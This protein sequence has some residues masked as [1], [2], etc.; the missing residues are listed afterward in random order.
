[1]KEFNALCDRFRDPKTRIEAERKLLEFRKSRNVLEQSINVVVSKNATG[2]AK[3]QATSVCRDVALESWMRIGTQ[4]QNTIREH[5]ITYVVTNYN[6]LEKFVS[7]QILH[8]V[9]SFY[10]RAWTSLAPRDKD[11]LFVQIETIMRQNVRCANAYLHIIVD[12]F[13]ASRSSAM[14]LKLEWHRNVQRDF[15]EGGG[16]KRCLEMGMIQIGNVIRLRSGNRS[17]GMLH[18]E[19]DSSDGYIVS[20][21]LKLLT[22]ILSFDFGCSNKNRLGR[23]D[24]VC[25]G[26]SWR[27]VLLEREL[28]NMLFRIYY[29]TRNNSKK[30]SNLMHAAREAIISMA[31]IHGDIFVSENARALYVSTILSETLRVFGTP[32]RHSELRDE[33]IVDLSRL[34]RRSV[35]SIGLSTILCMRNARVLVQNLKNLTIHLM[36]E[37]SNQSSLSNTWYCE[38]FDFLLEV[39]SHLA[40]DSNSRKNAEIQHFLTEQ[41]NSVFESYITYS[42]II[43]GKEEGE[44]EDE[45]T[46]GEADILMFEEQIDTAVSIGRFSASRAVSNLDTMIKNLMSKIAKG[47]NPKLVMGALRWCVRVSAFLLA[48]RAEGEEP[49]I[50]SVFM[51]PET[52]RAC[53]LLIRTVI[54]VASAD[55]S[56][57]LRNGCLMSTGLV[58]DLLNSMCRIFAT[59]LA[60]NVSELYVFSLLPLSFFQ[61]HSS[62]TSFLFFIFK[63]R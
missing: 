29:C 63:V 17:D 52:A 27:N 37:A 45:D 43:A 25:P 18:L 57:T 23:D 59:Y 14:G 54:N 2:F 51:I 16:L 32:L 28:L 7:K 33:E 11:A 26:P 48:D 15:S 10:K 5:L 22:Q 8:T 36:R 30:R 58:S 38:A 39:W 50:P 19:L 41:C 34:L 21:F 24:L 42:A 9:A 55:L 61:T 40:L 35:M 60:P 49:M 20:S 3:F 4:K 62:N 56:A 12:E 47:E 13:L 31:S 44:E 1:M 46:L 53:A 6:D